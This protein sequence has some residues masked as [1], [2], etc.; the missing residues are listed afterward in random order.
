[1]TT[2][3]L[4]HRCG[5]ELQPGRGNFYVVRIEAFADPSPP[6]ID[7]SESSEEIAM[8]IDAILAGLAD[9]SE[10]S[11]MDQIHRRLTLHLCSPCYRV[12]IEDPAPQ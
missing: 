3:L 11:L 4:C 2:P 1:M 10:S 9:E 7:G 6:T 5:A 8:E 12:W